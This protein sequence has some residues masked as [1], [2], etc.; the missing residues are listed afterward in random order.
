LNGVNF[1]RGPNRIG[2]GGLS[3]TRLGFASQ[4]LGD[5]RVIGVGFRLPFGDE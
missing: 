2:D 5:P 1:L 4:T 3:R